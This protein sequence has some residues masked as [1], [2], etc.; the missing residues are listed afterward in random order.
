MLRGGAAFAVMWYHFTQSRMFAG[1]LGLSDKLIKMS[2]AEGAIGVQV[3]YVLS[4]FV[5]PLSMS[6]SGYSL[7]DWSRFLQKRLVRIHPPYVA[8]IAIALA[9]WLLETGIPNYHGEP[10]QLEVSRLL[11][12]AWYGTAVVGFRW[13]VP[14]FWT[15]AIE[16]QYYAL[17]AVVFPLVMHKNRVIRGLVPVLLALMSVA[18]LRC[19]VS[20]DYLPYWLDYFAMGIVA[21]Q[22]QS[23]LM[24]ALPGFLLIAG[25]GALN[26]DGRFVPHVAG[27]ATA[28]LIAFAPVSIKS[29]WLAGLGAISYSLYLI[30]LPIG[31]RIIRVGTRIADDAVSRSFVL[32]VATLVSIFAAWLV[33]RWIEC[34]A[35]RWS[36]RIRYR[37]SNNSRLQSEQGRS[38]SPIPGTS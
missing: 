1:S 18:A 12:H 26:I 30:H 16:V 28:Y 24:P 10:F 14:V 31:G 4:G 25:F 3:F 23:R 36:S 38:N 20:R 7:A 17:I 9:V 15:L 6:R 21:F 35:Q 27:I 8:C 32:A 34:P 5:I 11:A 33:Y 37:R 19:G 22:V 13:Y 2:G 29:R